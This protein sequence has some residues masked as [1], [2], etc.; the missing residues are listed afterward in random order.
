VKAAVAELE[1]VG[2]M[3]AKT[4]DLVTI[5][6]RISQAAEVGAITLGLK[7][8][9]KLVEV[10]EVDYEF[11]NIDNENGLLRVAKIDAN[12]HVYGANDAILN[13]TARILA[14]VQG[15]ELFVLDNMTEIADPSAFV[16]DVTLNT[17][18]VS[19]NSVTNVVEPGMGRLAISNYPNPFRTETTI[20][21]NLP[22]SGRVSLVVY[23]NVGQV[24]ANLVNE[25]QDAGSQTVVLNSADLGG[26]DG[27]FIYRIVVEGQSRTYTGTGNLMLMK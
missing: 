17:V 18:A 24:V 6:V 5:P 13:V 22:E 14:D 12:G 7:Y 9:N 1:Y 2:E 23:N 26:N 10:V 27:M 4:G 11:S 19:S 8:D 25:V 3:E 20:S 21:Y 16:L 15:A